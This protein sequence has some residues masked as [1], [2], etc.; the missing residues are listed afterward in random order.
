M[1]GSNLLSALAMAGQSIVIVVALL[2]TSVSTTVIIM[3]IAPLLCAGVD[4]VLLKD[5]V[6]ARRLVL[7]VVGFVGVLIVV[8]TPAQ[9]STSDADHSCA[10]CGAL[11]AL[12]N[13][14]CWVVVFFLSKRKRS[15]AGTAP[16][17]ALC[18]NLVML[19]LAGMICAAMATVGAAATWSNLDAPGPD[20]VRAPPRR[21]A[22]VYAWLWYLLYGGVCLP[23]TQ[24]LLSAAVRHGSST[25]EVAAIKTIEVVL[26]PGL[27][28]AFV[29]RT[30]VPGV[31][32]VCGGVVIV[33]AVLAFSADAERDAR[34]AKLAAA[35]CGGHVEVGLADDKV[36]I[37]R[38]DSMRGTVADSP[39][40]SPSVS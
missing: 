4:V 9:T 18:R 33:L 16:E 36:P 34:R 14:L 39:L 17:D 26:G 31:G 40:N 5:A 27:V 22:D 12:I 29:D 19:L 25:S 7:L 24:Y 32:T 1:D 10:A 35:A 38:A 30:E 2:I 23:S 13:P 37:A 15:G 11:V 28:F 21:V 3:Q 8:L 6:P 20:A